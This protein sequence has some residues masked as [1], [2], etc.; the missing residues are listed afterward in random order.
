MDER[1]FRCFSDVDG[2]ARVAPRID[3]YVS[4]VVELPALRRSED[5]GERAHVLDEA[6]LHGGG[7]FVVCR[8][9]EVCSH[10]G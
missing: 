8:L 2:D 10:H 5:R 4:A 6:V 3:P 7:V 1:V 9:T